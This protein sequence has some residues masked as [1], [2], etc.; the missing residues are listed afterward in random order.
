MDRLAI[1]STSGN[2]Y[3]TSVSAGALVTGFIGVS[4]VTP[5]GDNKDLVSGGYTLRDIVVDPEERYAFCVFV[6]LT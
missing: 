3:Y 5:K 4:V 1:D 2:I 6:L